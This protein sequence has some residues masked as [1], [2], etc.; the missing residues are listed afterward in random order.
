M[1]LKGF[2]KSNRVA[3][4]RLWY[5][6]IHDGWFAPVGL[7]DGYI[8]KL[9]CTC[10]RSKG[11]SQVGCYLVASLFLGRHNRS[12][13]LSRLDAALR[14]ENAPAGVV[15]PPPTPAAYHGVLAEQGRLNPHCIPAVNVLGGIVADQDDHFGL[16]TGLP[17]P[18]RSQRRHARA[19]RRG[20]IAPAG[21]GRKAK[22]P[23]PALSPAGVSKGAG[24]ERPFDRHRI[25]SSTCS[26]RDHLPHWSHFY[27]G[28]IQGIEVL[29]LDDGVQAAVLADHP[30]RPLDH[31]PGQACAALRPIQDDLHRLA[32]QDHR[33]TLGEM[34]WA[35]VPGIGG[36]ASGH[37]HAAQCLVGMPVQGELEH[38]LDVQPSRKDRD[39]GAIEVELCAV[40]FLHASLPQPNCPAQTSG[41]SVQRASRRFWGAYL[42]NARRS[43]IGSGRS[44][45]RRG[46]ICGIA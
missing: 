24:L 1:L 25:S 3:P 23:E 27:A 14:R 5:G 39:I 13:H 37:D 12:C 21:W 10:R 41:V 7:D 36:R 16:Q 40:V 46:C 19:K 32:G 31:D 6:W 9:N 20:G 33:E 30:Q 18:P 35:E 8:E 34:L 45:G 11:F 28:D 15:V 38:L 44:A 42:P 26:L 17:R 29:G 22:R 4:I 2:L 43:R